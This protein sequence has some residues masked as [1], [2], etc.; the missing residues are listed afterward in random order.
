MTKRKSKDKGD[1]RRKKRKKHKNKDKKKPKKTPKTK[2]EQA[3]RELCEV[4]FNSDGT[5]DILKRN[6]TMADDD[7]IMDTVRTRGL[8]KKI[9]VEFLCTPIIKGISA[10][11][12]NPEFGSLA[13]AWHDKSKRRIEWHNNGLKRKRSH[14]YAGKFGNVSKGM[15]KAII[16]GDHPDVHVASST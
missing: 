1:D 14:G 10:S 13:A 15:V 5:H 16:N 3:H 11:P 6:L 12:R 8:Y 7:L 4:H 2:P 9:F